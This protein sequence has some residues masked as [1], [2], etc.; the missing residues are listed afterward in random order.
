MQT[1][2]R[3]QTAS[4]PHNSLSSRSPCI[5]NL[6]RKGAADVHAPLTSPTWPRG[7]PAPKLKSTAQ[8]RRHGPVESDPAISCRCAA[9][10]SRGSYSS[11]DCGAAI[12]QDSPLWRILLAAGSK[13]VLLA[14]IE[15]LSPGLFPTV[16]RRSTGS[17]VKLR[18]L[19]LPD[20]WAGYMARCIGWR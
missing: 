10:A 16:N 1:P 20:G 15:T 14:S 13:I 5:G 2:R 3:S 11:T 12:S 19:F 7:W 8:I 9:P 6:R 17:R 18:L 4:P